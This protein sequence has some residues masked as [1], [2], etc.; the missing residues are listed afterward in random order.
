MQKIVIFSETLGITQSGVDTRTFFDINAEPYEFSNDATRPV[1]FVLAPS[2]HKHAKILFL[3]IWH[4]TENQHKKILRLLEDPRR[5]VV[6]NLINPELNHPRHVFVDF[7]FNRTKAYYSQFPFQVGTKPWYY[8][9][10]QSFID[11]ELV[12]AES[13]KKIFISPS[14]TYNGT[15]VHRTMI[16]KFLENYKNIG[17]LSNYDDQGT[18]LYPHIEF[19]YLYSIEDLEQQDRPL[20]YN[21]WGY[22][23][24]HNAY[25]QNTFI[26]IYGETIEYGDTYIVSEKTYDPLIKGH[27]ILP[28]SNKGFIALLKEQGILF[29]SFIDYSYDNIAD[30]QNRFLAYKDEAQRLLNMSLDDWRQHYQ[31]SLELL[32][33]NKL[34]FHQ[35]NY[36]RVKLSSFND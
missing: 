4:G 2:Q 23:P 17:Y 29:P 18:F 21:F 1:D 13:K 20:S 14:M 28:F 9:G 11:C 10:I 35:R 34:W 15:R 19:P 24:P 22:C 12:S 6:S 36:H 26:S 3:D 8:H 25:Y 32:Y 16:V 31:N 33:Q 30:N 27:F 5:I 7:V